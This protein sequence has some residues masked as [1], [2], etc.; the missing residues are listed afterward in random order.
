MKCTLPCK[1]CASG[2]PTSCNTCYSNINIDNRIFY[3]NNNCFSSCPNTTIVSSS[4]C[5]PCDSGCTTCQTVITNCTSCAT[6]KYLNIITNPSSGT[7][8]TSCPSGSFNNDDTNPKKCTSCT[9]PCAT[10]SNSSD[11]LSCITGYLIGTNCVNSCPTTGF[12]VQN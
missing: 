3:A 4:A 1:T 6:G 8:V 9:S 2:Q 12:Y 10:C 5:I 11:C 7:C